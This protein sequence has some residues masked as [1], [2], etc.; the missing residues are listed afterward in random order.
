MENWKHIGALLTGIAALITASIPIASYLQDIQWFGISKIKQAQP[1]V[2]T[3]KRY[4]FIDD[5]DG[6]V[7]V[8]V[9]PSVSS[10]VITK[11][12]NGYRVEVL[13]KKGNWYRVKTF[14]DD[15]GYIY[16]DRL[17][18]KNETASH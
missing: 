3:S 6:W 10:K 15:I 1:Q 18:I 16:G 9:E 17:I 2:S 4:A 5:P 13:E 11:I 12:E 14:I 7:N 8:R